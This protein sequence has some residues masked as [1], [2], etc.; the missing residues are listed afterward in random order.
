MVIYAS[1]RAPIDYDVNRGED[2]DAQLIK[3]QFNFKWRKH[4]FHLIIFVFEQLREVAV[5]SIF[6]LNEY[7]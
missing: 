1:A 3:A 2:T 7:W 6:N 4:W 5:Q